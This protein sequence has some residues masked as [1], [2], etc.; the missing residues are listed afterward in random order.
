MPDCPA[1]IAQRIHTP[2]ERAVY[3]PLASHG[4]MDGHGWTCPEA[5][6]A[7]AA[8]TPRGKEKTHGA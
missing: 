3:H 7:H 6:E 8:A 5:E 2:E 1:C 4:W